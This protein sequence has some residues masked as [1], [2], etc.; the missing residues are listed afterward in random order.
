M[1]VLLTS[2]VPTMSPTTAVWFATLTEILSALVSV[3]AYDVVLTLELVRLT[4]SAW[5]LLSAAFNL[6]QSE[7]V[8]FCMPSSGVVVESAISTR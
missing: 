3:M 1:R 6:T 8:S 2:V 7:A 4:S 5:A